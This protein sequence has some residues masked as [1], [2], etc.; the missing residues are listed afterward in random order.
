MDWY[1]AREIA[2]PRNEFLTQRKNSFEKIKYYRVVMDI[3][4]YDNISFIDK[5]SVKVSQSTI[6][7]KLGVYAMQTENGIFEM[8]TGK[9]LTVIGETDSISCIG[10]RELGE[11]EY[12]TAGRC[13]VILRDNAETKKQ[14]I[15][16][17]NNLS[18]KSHEIN[19]AYIEFIDKQQKEKKEA[20][21][22]FKSYKLP[23][24]N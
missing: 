10:I 5:I 3:D 23:G 9:K 7:E 2:K 21:Q 11:N 15:N 20:L 6:D 1:I 18:K 4:T 14:Y 22:Y 17:L 24:T 8:V 19:E 12:E 13:L 16:I